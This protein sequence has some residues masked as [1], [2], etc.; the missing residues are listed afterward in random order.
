MATARITPATLGAWLVK[1][2]PRAN[3]DLVAAARGGVPLVVTR[4]CVSDNYRGRMMAPGDRVLLWVSGDGRLLTRGIWGLG[5]VTAAVRPR[6]GD[7]RPEVGLDVPLLPDGVPAEEVRAAGAGDLEVLR[8][9]AGSNPSWVSREQ[10]AVL[11]PLLPA[12][13]AGSSDRGAAKP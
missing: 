1:T 3:P 11:V 8:M 12:W 10:L 9:P 4:R 7:G 5:N 2:D 13:P 6:D